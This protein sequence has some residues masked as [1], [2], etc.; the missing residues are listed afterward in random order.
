MIGSYFVVHT[1]DHEDY[2]VWQTSSHEVVVIIFEPQLHLF[3]EYLK[4]LIDTVLSQGG[5]ICN[6]IGCWIRFNKSSDGVTDIDVDL[7]DIMEGTG[8]KKKV[9][10]SDGA[11][12]GYFIIVV[13]IGSLP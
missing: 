12:S 3:S 13:D 1:W 9:T 4:D 6:D 8:T 11:S 5:L 10:T 7:G 2:L